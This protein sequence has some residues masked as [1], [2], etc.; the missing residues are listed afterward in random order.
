MKIGGGSAQPLKPQ[1][2]HQKAMMH[3]L[4]CTIC[5]NKL[6]EVSVAGVGV[7]WGRWKKCSPMANHDGQE[8]IPIQPQLAISNK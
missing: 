4:I 2:V 5:W 7:V 1:G 3:L 8:K 6:I